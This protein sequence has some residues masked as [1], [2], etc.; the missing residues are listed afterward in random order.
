MRKFQNCPWYVKFWRY[1]WYLL[2]PLDAII[3]YFT[4]WTDVDSGENKLDDTWNT[5]EQSWSISIGLAQCKMKWFYST[6]DVKKQLIHKFKK[7][8]FLI[9]LK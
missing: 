8:K 2:I 3:I 7:K 4:P 1:R 9:T 5:W 6:E